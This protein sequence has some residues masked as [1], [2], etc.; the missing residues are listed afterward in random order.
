MFRKVLLT[1]AIAVMPA[2]LVL[3]GGSLA[4]ASTTSASTVA[5][6]CP[7]VI[8]ITHLAFSPP[9]VSPGQLSTATVTARNCTGQTQQTSVIWLA[10]FTGSGP[11]IPPGCPAIDPL[12]PPQVTFAPFGKFTAS[13]GFLV[14]PSCP[15]TQLQVTFD[16]DQNGAVI[17]SKTADLI[18]VPPP[19]TG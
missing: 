14:P 15:A 12:P 1:A 10:R 4:A 19:A 17:A 5:A 6:A 11:G 13:A 9:R 7:G 3:A 18:I 2:G 8:Q 16:V